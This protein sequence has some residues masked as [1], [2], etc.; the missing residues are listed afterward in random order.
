M[1]N[2]A[3]LVAHAHITR[4]LHPCWAQSHARHRTRGST[5]I[6]GHAGAGAEALDLQARCGGD[7]GFKASNKSDHVILILSETFIN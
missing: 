4:C 5:S 2:A 7:R 3:R 1:Q 6:V